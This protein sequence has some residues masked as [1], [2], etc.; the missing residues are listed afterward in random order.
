MPPFGENA[1]AILEEIEEFLTGAR[2]VHDDADRTLVTL[3][4]TD[5]V[6]STSR[7]ASMGDQ[8]WRV[9][10]DRF[11]ER[12]RQEVARHRGH[13]VKSIGD[14]ILA[15]FDSPARG[16]RCAR[17][18]RDAV[19]QLGLQV[20]AGLHVG[21]V[22]MRDGDVGG[23]AVHVAARVMALAAPGEVLASSALPSM[24]I[25]TGIAFEPRGE[26]ELRG[27]PGSWALYAVP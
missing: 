6:E 9:L 1:D 25:G 23:I 11:G 16:L 12:A 21:E 20:R 3:L 7:A 27:V 5:I 4:F 24:V 15:T 18:I 8:Q 22:D 10:L 19:D 14:G 13:V 17:A 26:H 2:H